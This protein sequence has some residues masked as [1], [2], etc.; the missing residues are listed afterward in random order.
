MKPVIFTLA[1]VYFLVDAIFMTVARPLANWIGEYRIFRSVRVWIGS[2]R[3]YPAL[4]LL[5][6]PVIVLEPVKPVAAYLAGTGHI[7]TGMIV[8]V[9]GESLK[10]V[11][12]ER[13]FCVSR[14]KL[15]SIP[16]FACTYGKYWQAKDWL[17]SLEAWQITRRWMRL[18]Q[19][20]VRRYVQRMKASHKLERLPV[21]LR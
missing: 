6:V 9:V 12:V 2:L 20:V 18:A 21:Q 7:T 4:A 16:A 19:C 1:A 17:E 5:A 8:L 10:L 13:L 15:M 14:D 3:P 11:L